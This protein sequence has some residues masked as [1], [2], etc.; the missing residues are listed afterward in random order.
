MKTNPD[1]IILFLIDGLR[2]DALK[3]SHT[4]VIDGIRQF[5]ASSF[6]TKTVMPSLTLPCHTSLFTSTVPETHGVTTNDW[7][8]TPPSCDSLIQNGLINTIKKEGGKTAAFYNWDPLGDLTRAGAFDR[9]I[10]FKDNESMQGDQV[11]TEAAVNWFKKNTFTFAFIYLGYVDMAGHADGWMSDTYLKAIA[12]VDQC[13][14]RVL[15]VVPKNTSIMIT[16]DHGGHGKHHGTNCDEDMTTPFI[17]KGSGVPGNHTIKRD[18]SIIDIA[19]TIL[20]RLDIEIPQ[21]WEGNAITFGP[22]KSASSS[23][24]ADFAAYGT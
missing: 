15:Q 13:I 23:D 19:P 22:Q 3:A 6:N 20:R 18:M 5:G 1:P 17:I 11:V 9:E 16:S 21:N 14:E 8:S 24:K 4:P 12:N 10:S 2:P 7:M